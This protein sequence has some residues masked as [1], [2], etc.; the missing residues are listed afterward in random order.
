MGTALNQR[1]AAF[2]EAYLHNGG[3]AKKAY[4]KVYPDAN[5]AT[6]E[7]NG[8]KLLSLTK[9]QQVICER[10]AE[11]LEASTIGI[12]KKRLALW[13][14]VSDSMLPDETSK[15]MKAP[16]AAI[17]AIAELNRMDGHFRQ[18][19]RAKVRDVL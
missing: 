7:V 5:C 9:V 8:H 10:R 16:L 12:E 11:I 3:N 14:I 13:N 18:Y 6:Q 4:A 1:Q 2:V 15:K 19:G 17:A